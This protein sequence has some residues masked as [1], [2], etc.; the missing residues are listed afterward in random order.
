MSKPA[1]LVLTSTFPR[2][3]GDTDPR[4]VFDLCRALG[5]DFDVH[6]VAPHCAGARVRESMDGVTV[7]RFRYQP[8]RWE[9]LAYAGGIPARLRARPLRY[10]QVPFFLLGQ[11]LLVLRLVRQ[12]DA[13][14]LHAHWMLPQGLVALLARRLCRGR[15]A[16]LCTAHGADIFTLRSGPVRWLLGQVARRVQC[17]TVVSRSMVAPAQALGVAPERIHVAPMGVDVDGIFAAGA[18][19]REPGRVVFAG[20]LVP[21]KG[22]RHLVNAMAHVMRQ[23]PEAR[24]TIIGDGPDRVA[25]ETQ[26]AALGL[27]GHVT[28]T[29]A[30]AQAD[31]AHHLRRAAAAVF[32]FVVAADGDAEGLGLAVV[33][34]QAC[35]CPVIASDVPALADTVR[36]GE[37]GLLVSPGEESALAAAIVRV[38]TEPGLATHLSG[39]GRTSARDQFGWAKVSARYL[40]ILHQVERENP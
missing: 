16:V 23:L 34:A 14:V 2:R 29:G 10:L 21:K 15:P 13:R 17:L 28:F 40:E 20:R 5:R 35:G 38:L 36:A 39:Q 4:F 6:V 7:H 30:L 24:L 3:A 9:T 8:E 12:L 11:L 33:E 22:A 37:T 19:A 32:P 25:L 1:L 31:L 18:D 27:T 26:C